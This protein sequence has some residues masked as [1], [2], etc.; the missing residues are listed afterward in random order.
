MDFQGTHGFISEPQIGANH[1]DPQISVILLKFV[2]RLNCS[3]SQFP[4]SDAAD[5]QE[6]LSPLSIAD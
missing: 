3:G 5:M 1:T 2:D 4:L 6:P